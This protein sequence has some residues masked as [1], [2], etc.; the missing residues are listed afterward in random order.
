EHVLGVAELAFGTAQ[1]EED[2]R[3]PLLNYN[4]DDK[5]LKWCMEIQT[6]AKKDYQNQLKQYSE[7]FEATKALEAA[8]DEANPVYIEHVTLTRMVLRFNPVKLIKFGIKGRRRRNNFQWVQQGELYYDNTLE[9][10]ELLLEL[11][12]RFGLT[13]EKLEAGRKLVL[14]VGEALRVQAKERGEAQQATVDRDKSFREL[15]YALS[16]FF[17]VCRFALAPTPQLLEKVGI[18]KFSEGYRRQLK[19]ELEEPTPEEIAEE[20]A[21]GETTTEAT[22]STETTA[23][24][25]AAATGEESPASTVS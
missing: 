19:E 11:N 21:A 3:T 2:V 1:E 12:E 17:Q 7:Q 4:Y 8:F 25:P 22:D 14:N 18:L 9:D 5:K 20:A 15:Y 6:V 13:K 10:E 16:D 24:D 23:T